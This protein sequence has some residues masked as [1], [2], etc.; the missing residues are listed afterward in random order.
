MFVR[1]LL[2]SSCLLGLTSAHAQAYGPDTCK[3]GYVWREATPDDHVCVI[4]SI[5]TQARRDNAQA[6]FR[7]SPSD[8]SY[9]PDTCRSGYV[10]R[11]ALEGDHVCVSPA[12]REQ[13]RTDNAQATSRYVEP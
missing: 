12:V 7:V 2:L 1:V 11:E 4:P 8:R 5:R 10:W 13:V 9:G 3:T 6:R